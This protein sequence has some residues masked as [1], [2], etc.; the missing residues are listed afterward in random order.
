MAPRVKFA[1]ILT[2]FVFE[3][4]LWNAAYRE[5]TG[6]GFT[7]IIQRN[8]DVKIFHMP[9]IYHVITGR[10]VD[11]SQMDSAESS[12]FVLNQTLF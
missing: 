3:T 12:Q 7:N 5:Q 1:I 6:H 8:L 2:N 10:H 4:P 9:A 11:S